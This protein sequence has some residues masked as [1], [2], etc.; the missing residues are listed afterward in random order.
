MI[1]IIRVSILR[2]LNKSKNIILKMNFSN[3]INNNILF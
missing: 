1:V 3:Y 2:Y